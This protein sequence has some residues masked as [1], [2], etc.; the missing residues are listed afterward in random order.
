MRLF[1]MKH[2]TKCK[3][4]KEE[5]EF[6]KNRSKRDGL[7]TECHVCNRAKVKARRDANPE[8]DREHSRL[9]RLANPERAKLNLS[10]WY[11]G[12]KEKV[13]AYERKMRETNPQK[14]FEGHRKAS[15]KYE[16]SHPDKMAEGNHMRRARMQKA[17]GRITAKEWQALKEFYGYTC[18]CCGRKEPEIKLELD[19]VIPISKGGK[20]LVSNVQCLCASCNR[21]KNARH[22]DYRLVVFY[23]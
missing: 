18:L 16:K 1:K 23:G 14:F 12:N 10:R 3:Q 4:W 13:R 7:A 9:W 8:K 2:C 20:N 5:G 6:P 19:H 11:Q 22:I 21:R 15:S 17:E